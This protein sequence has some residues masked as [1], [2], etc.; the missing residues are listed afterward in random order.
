MKTFSLALSLIASIAALAISGLNFF[1]TSTF[2]ARVED[3]LSEQA[4]L[5]QAHESA[6]A[7]VVASADESVADRSGMAA[8]TQTVSQVSADEIDVTDEQP[9]SSA[10]S[11]ARAI[12]PGEFSQKG[13]DNQATVE[14]VS[15][16]RL[17]N[18]PEI[19]NFSLRIRRDVETSG[20]GTGGALGLNTAKARNPQTNEVYPGVRGKHTTFTT[21]RDLPYDTW[22]N[23]YFWLEVP[24]DVNVVD[25]VIPDNAIFED[26]PISQ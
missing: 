22:A 4:T 16:E 3:Q 15:A 23:A 9:E 14:I 12:Q 7:E 8:R 13:Y 24:E 11:S 19:V 17:S 26:V 6:L 18:S 10:G 5:L 1:K 25:V 20:R 2:E 21:I